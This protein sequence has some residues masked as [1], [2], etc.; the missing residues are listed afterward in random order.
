MEEEPE[1]SSS[2][3][4]KDTSSV[5][6]EDGVKILVQDG[7]YLKPKR[8]LTAYNLFFQEERR[9]MLEEKASQNSPAK[10]GFAVMAR[11]VS[12]RWKVI[13]VPMRQ[14]Y[15]GLAAQDKIRYTSEIKVWKKLEKEATRKNKQKQSNKNKA[16]PKAESD[17]ARS[18]K[19]QKKSPKSVTTP[20]RNN[21][22][23]KPAASISAP[24][25]DAV[26]PLPLHIPH[27]VHVPS[28]ESSSKNG[29]SCRH[30]AD[31]DPSYM[32]SLD[33]LFSPLLSQSTSM[34]CWPQP[35]GP[36]QQ[37]QG[38]HS[39]CTPLVDIL[40]QA[41]E[42][43]QAMT[44]AAP[45]TTN[46]GAAMIGGHDDDD[47]DIISAEDLALIAPTDQ[48]QDD[49]CSLGGFGDYQHLVASMDYRQPQEQLLGSS[50]AAAMPATMVV[51]P[52]SS[53]TSQSPDAACLNV[54]SS[55]SND[56]IM[57][58][59]CAN[60]FVSTVSSPSTST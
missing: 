42:I 58:M 18:P 49:D 10:I 20:P 56:T 36:Q 22:N 16:A 28:S 54:F 12:A 19:K 24:S 40:S 60:L 4:N 51:T 34:A 5:H 43:S 25:L 33:Q 17:V 30:S 13:D 31:A 29:S 8:S 57:G 11:T 26:T 59:D 14:H 1:I 41:Y 53:M 2:S 27:I 21:N 23:T 15:E 46:D 47:E 32:L 37:Q 35:E 55:L 45:L 38:F 50:S 7:C 48:G 52:R 9:K 6:V 39:A 3:N 44:D